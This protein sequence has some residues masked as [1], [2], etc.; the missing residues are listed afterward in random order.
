MPCPRRPPVSPQPALRFRRPRPLPHP[1][2]PPP[3]PPQEFV[4]QEPEQ[5]AGHEPLDPP[6]SHCS[7]GSTTPLPHTPGTLAVT[8]TCA[9]AGRNMICH[10]VINATHATPTSVFVAFLTVMPCGES[11]H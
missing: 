4:V 11:M 7:P 8:D 2:P 6:A 9:D 3:P 5:A 1:P 10:A